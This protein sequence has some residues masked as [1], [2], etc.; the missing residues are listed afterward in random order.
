MVTGTTFASHD[1]GLILSNTVADIIASYWRS[2]S[3]SISHT[4]DAHRLKD[5][6]NIAADIMELILI[7]I[8]SYHIV[9][10]LCI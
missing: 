6:S 4:D 3:G 5:S 8:L 1:M 7:V 2:S 9:S 10:H